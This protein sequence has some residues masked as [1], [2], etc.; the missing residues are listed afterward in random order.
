[1]FM[2]TTLREQLIE[3]AQKIRHIPLVVLMRNSDQIDIPCV[4]TDGHA[5]GAEI[6]DILLD[7]GHVRIGYL[8][9][10]VSERTEL[11]RL[12]GFRSR[13]QARGSALAVVLS[14][15]HYRRDEAL[16]AFESYLQ[17]VPREQRVEAIFCENDILAIGVLDA[18]ERTGLRRRIAVMGFDDID[19]AASPHFELST[20]RQ[21]VDLLVQEAVRRV[22]HP[23]QQAGAR[24]LMVP[25]MLVLRG[26]HRR[27]T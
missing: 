3:L 19:L 9:G 12:E 27:M 21:P 18:L 17:A 22:L 15:S 25:G 5:A 20:F 14:A 2:G 13:L 11:R 23:Q 1:M 26:S 6:A 10:P 16:R 4:T 24:S 7:Q 8:A